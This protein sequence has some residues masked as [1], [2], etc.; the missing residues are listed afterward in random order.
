MPDDKIDRLAPARRP[1]E[2]PVGYQQW[3]RLAFLHW[4]VDPVAVQ[5]KLPAGLEVD[6]YDGRA[7]VGLVPFLMTGVRPRWFPP[8]PGVSTFCETN[9]RTYVTRTNGDGVREPGVYFF[10]LDAA[11]W[12]ATLV[13]RGVWRLPYYRAKMSLEADG[14][15]TVYTSSR[16]WPGPRGAGGRVEI[17]ATGPPEPAEPRFARPF[18]VRAIPAVHREP[19]PDPAG[20]SA[21]HAVSHPAGTGAVSR[22]DT[23]RGGGF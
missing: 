4:P 1:A 12:V 21:S 20:A 23:L 5:D 22:R 9:V 3:R 7:W 10:S 16:L 17:E 6:T 13:A 15:R 18:P 14:D 2:S 11:A 8:V 19:R